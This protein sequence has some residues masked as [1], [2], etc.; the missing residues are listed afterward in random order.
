MKLYPLMAN[1]E[2]CNVLVVGGGEVATRKV[3][4]L[5]G[6][7]ARV[8]VIS[9]KFSQEIETLISDG[10]IKGSRRLFSSDDL[11]GSALVFAATDDPN[12]NDNISQE[13][14]KMG[15]PTNNATNPE[16]C[17]FFVP[18]Q[19]IRGDLILAISTS[20]KSPATAKWIRQTIEK[21]LNREYASLI[22]WMGTLRRELTEEG[23]K[24]SQTGKIS[25]Y[26]LEH[27]ILTKL[28][29]NDKQGTISLLKAAFQ[30]TLKIPVPKPVIAK[31]G[32]T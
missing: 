32:L 8:K 11:N 24:A 14:R 30:T 4:A 17:T 10:K 16:G 29:I 22:E 9:P 19:I 26:L 7:G 12:L 28:K 27:D 23:F 2:E 18:S 31:L 13:A 20:G 1:L 5:L 6:T 15:I 25:E 21:H 3:R